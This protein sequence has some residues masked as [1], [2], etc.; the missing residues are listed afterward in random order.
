MNWFNVSFFNFNAFFVN[1]DP[2]LLLPIPKQGR[3]SEH[4][5]NMGR[6]LTNTFNPLKKQ[7]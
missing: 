5:C 3:I 1:V 6:Y 7:K 4:F 2:N